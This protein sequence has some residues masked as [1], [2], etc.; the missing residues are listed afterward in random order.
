MCGIKCFLDFQRMHCSSVLPMPWIYPSEDLF[1]YFVTHCAHNLHLSYATIKL[2]LA[3]LRIFYVEQGFGNPLI[4]ANGSMLPR[5]QLVL[6][7]V[8]KSLAKPSQPRFPITYPILSRMFTALDNGM[9][10]PYLDLLFKTVCATA[11]FGFLRCG[12]FTTLHSTFDPDLHLTMSDINLFG[13]SSVSPTRASVN[14]KSSKTDPFRQ[15]CN[16]HL[17]PTNSPICAVTLLGLF[18]RVRKTM[19]ASDKDPLFLLPG[20]QSLSRAKFIS[21]LRLVLTRIGLQASN[22][23]GH[24]FRRGAASTGSSVHIPDHVIKIL[25]RW[26]SDCYQRYI[27]IPLHVLSSAHCAMA[28][29]RC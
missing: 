9:F 16:I 23:S 21:M 2:Y 19:G 4:S 14:L 26:S 6:R 13:D 8:K 20:N 10:G 24:S 18:I 7:G 22:F 25:G 29:S 3:G 15:G 28:Q 17:F 11:F 27:D 5:L 12:E 1:V